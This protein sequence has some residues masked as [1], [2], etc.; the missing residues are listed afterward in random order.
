LPPTAPA[1]LMCPM[2]D[3]LPMLDGSFLYVLD[4][5]APVLGIQ[6]PG[7]SGRRMPNTK[8]SRQTRN[9]C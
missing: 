4:G 7:V 1:V 6:R 8:G 9:A 5:G 2:E 3:V